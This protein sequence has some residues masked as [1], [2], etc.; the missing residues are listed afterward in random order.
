VKTKL[1]K[2]VNRS[3]GARTFLS[4]ATSGRSTALRNSSALFQ[5]QPAADKNVRAPGLPLRLSA[6]FASLRFLHVGHPTA[7]VRYSSVCLAFVLTLTAVAQPSPLRTRNARNRAGTPPTQAT[8]S[9]DLSV[10]QQSQE[11]ALEQAQALEERAADE[12]AKA[13]VEAATKEMEKALKLLNEAKDSPAKL[14][15]AISAEQAASQA[16]LRLSAHEYQVSQSKSKSGKS[17]SQAQQRNQRQIDQLDLKQS[18]NKYETQRQATP[19]QSAEQQEQLQI[20]SRLKELAQRQQDLNDRLK[21]LQTALQEAKTEQEREEIRRRLKRL[22]EEEKEMLADVDELRQ[23]MDKPENQSKMAEARQLLDQTRSKV[24]QAA[25][26]MDKESVPDAL[27]SGTRAQRDLQQLRDDFRKKNSNQFSEEMRQMRSD[28]RELAQKQEEI[29]KKLDSIIDN[30]RKT[31]GDPDD[32]R[33]VAEQLRQQKS[34]VTNL[35][36]NMR[37]VSEQTETA[38]PLLSKQLYDTLRKTGQD[39]AQS[40]KQTTEELLRSGMLSRSLYDKIKA[41]DDGKGGKP[42]EVT[43]ELLDEKMLPQASQAEQRARQG[44]DELKRGVERAAESILGDDTEALRQAK[45]ELDDLT[46]QLENEIAQADRNATNQSKG[47]GKGQ[48]N[49]SSTD[50]KSGQQQAGTDGQKNG[51]GQSDAQA[52]QQSDQQGNGNEQA[53][54]E[55]SDSQGKG[56]Q[57]QGR[58]NEGQRD[59]SNQARN[60]QGQGQQ[61]GENPGGQ[62]RADQRD[63][64]EQASDG[65]QSGDQQ[66]QNP[67]QQGSQGQRGNQPGKGQQPGQNGQNGEQP[68]QANDQQQANQRGQG[69]GQGKGQGQ[70]QGQGRGSEQ[71]ATDNPPQQPNAREPSQENNP[72]KGGPGQRG[73]SGRQG[74]QNLLGGNVNGGEGGGSAHRDRFDGPLTGEDFSGWSDR[75][76]NVEEMVDLPDV[77]NEVARVR[78]RAKAVRQ[79]SRQKGQKPDWAVVRLEIS[80]P[81]AEVRNRITEELARRQSQDALVPIDR[82]PVPN[83][84]SEL[85]RQYY[86]KLGAANDK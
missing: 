43:S 28:A 83:K 86:E 78:E 58:Q 81:L 37:R 84:F 77:R 72:Q 17:Q 51:K 10:V 67:G 73:G 47:K 44:I 56:G 14:A 25:E 7:W 8:S 23:R 18:E 35:L 20:L 69:Q 61:P 64:S 48:Q 46:R 2:Q 12:R 13:L 66:G 75:L 4:A 52:N 53:S 60:G 21:E 5:L 11:Q 16:L 34:G 62:Q 22:R 50:G 6:L 55:K 31:L 57:G 42:L 40:V 85:V 45:R 39:E 30:K 80:H 19:Q 82:D 26:A 29:G 70:G 79:E 68:Q 27:A 65:Q 76:R 41:V 59:P 71:A 74:L 38:E 54:N 32:A 15:E 63:P 36:E 24:Q 3:P 9:N 49:A 33:A 1:P